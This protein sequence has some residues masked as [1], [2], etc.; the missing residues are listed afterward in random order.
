VLTQ[1]LAA[2]LRF[3][4]E[5]NPVAPARIPP[6]EDSAQDRRP[7]D[8]GDTVTLSEPGKALSRRFTMASAQEKDEA[9]SQEPAAITALKERIE[10]VKQKLEELRQ[11]DLPE[12]EKKR[13]EVELAGQLADLQNQLLLAYEEQEKAAAKAGS[14][15]AGS[16]GEGGMTSTSAYGAKR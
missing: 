10:Q 3:A 5:T 11:G 8:N 9:E 16:S 4:P 2:G 6:V 12:E 15:R 14:A 13:K 7:G 1:A